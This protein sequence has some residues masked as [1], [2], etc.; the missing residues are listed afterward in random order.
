M[1]ARAHPGVRPHACASAGWAVARGEVII[2]EAQAAQ[3]EVRIYG[4]YRGRDASHK[5]GEAAVGD[6]FGTRAA[7][8]LAAQA[9]DHALH[10]AD[11]AEDDA[12]LHAVDGVLAEGGGWR[13]QLD[14]KQA[15][16]GAGEGFGRDAQAGGDGAAE[17]VALRRDAVEAGG[18]AE[19][20]DDGG[21]AV[22]A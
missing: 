21:A 3:D 15:R 8:N 5:L 14:L 10:Q 6:D 4:V 9:R 12:A 17:E 1:H 16:G 19:L 20:D 11:M 7:G 13:R 2:D 18:G 22:E